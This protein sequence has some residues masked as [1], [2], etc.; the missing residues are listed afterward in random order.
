MNLKKFFVRIYKVF[1]CYR[2]MYK[3]NKG[4]IFTCFIMMVGLSG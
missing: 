4:L 3:I 2:N 1:I